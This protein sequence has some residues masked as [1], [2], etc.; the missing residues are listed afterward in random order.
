MLNSRKCS[1]SDILTGTKQLPVFGE[2]YAATT[3]H[4]NLA[5]R[6]VGGEAYLPEADKVA[7]ERMGIRG[8]LVDSGA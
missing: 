7:S 6:I 4:S 5:E 2:D 1:T 8:G 3:V